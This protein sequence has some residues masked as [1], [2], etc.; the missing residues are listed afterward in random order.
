MRHSYSLLLSR[1]PG[2]IKLKKSLKSS[3]ELRLCL[4]SR[5]VKETGIAR[6]KNY[7]I[8]RFFKKLVFGKCQEPFTELAFCNQNFLPVS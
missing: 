7:K 6:S 5:V 2:T 4:L 3:F 1:F 8:G